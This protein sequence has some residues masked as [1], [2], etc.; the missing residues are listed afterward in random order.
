MR[1]RFIVYDTVIQNIVGCF[2]TLDQAKEIF[3]DNKRFHFMDL[4]KKEEKTC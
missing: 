2:D 4:G 1:K 3:T